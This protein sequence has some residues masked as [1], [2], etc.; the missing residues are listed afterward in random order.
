MAIEID[1][2]TAL[3]NQRE[4][5]A[6]WTVARR[7][8][9]RGVVVPI[10]RASFQL[11]ASDTVFTMGSCFARNIEKHLVKFGCRVPV[12]EFSLPASERLSATP[13]Q[14]L[15]LFTP[16]LFS[17][18]IEWVEKI[19]SRD[20]KVTAEDCEQWLFLYPDGSALDLGL[21][22]A[23]PVAAQR[24]I[25]RRQEI[26]DL[27]ANVFSAECVMMTPGLVEAWFDHQHCIYTNSAPIKDGA[28]LDEQRYSFRVLNHEDCYQ[29]LVRVIDLIR[30]HN[31]AVKF[32]VTVSPVPLRYTFSDRDILIANT[33]SKSVLR[34]ACGQLVTDRTGIDYFP[35]FETVNLSTWRVWQKDRRH[36]SDALVDR[37]VKAVIA[38]YFRAQTESELSE[39]QYP[40]FQRIW[41]TT[42]GF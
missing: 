40:F 29:S 5:K 11:K 10:H 34:S 28:L 32:L 9:R 20:C 27:Y 2:K 42:F 25:E 7:R 12:H 3:K 13:N 16:P 23:K 8:L 1:A 26:F 41:R 36:V 24:A 4:A 33:Y 6:D 22:A 37:I 38:Q 14:A 39:L 35:S 31:R 18:T 30:K 19:Y 17:Q 15:T 21:A